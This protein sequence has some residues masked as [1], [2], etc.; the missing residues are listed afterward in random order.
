MAERTGEDMISEDPSG[1]FEACFEEATVDGT[2]AALEELLYCVNAPFEPGMTEGD[3][4]AGEDPLGRFAGDG[5]CTAA[6]YNG[7]F[8]V[9]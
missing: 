8:S 1:D 9:N 2:P 7:L 4:G 5:T 3:G 6:C